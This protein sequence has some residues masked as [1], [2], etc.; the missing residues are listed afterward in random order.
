MVEPTATLGV[1][2][3]G[4]VL[5]L[6]GCEE[7]PPQPFSIITKAAPIRTA[8]ATAME[9]TLRRRFPIKPGS[10]ISIES[11]PNSSPGTIQYGIQ[12]GAVFTFT[13]SSAFA[14]QVTWLGCRA[15]SR[16]RSSLSHVL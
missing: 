7:L 13:T 15:A 1:V 6:A 3:G 8:K 4:G 11:M 12:S 14:A 10:V 5:T 16:I 2:T 9:R